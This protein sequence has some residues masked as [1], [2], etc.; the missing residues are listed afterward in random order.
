MTDPARAPA[1]PPTTTDE[2]AF[3]DV[4]GTLAKTTVVHYY[5]YFKRRRMPTFVGAIW[6]TCFL[7]KCLYFLLID[8]IDRGWF[9]TRFYKSYRG[10]PEAQIKALAEDCYREMLLPRRFAQA[11]EEIANHKQAGRRIVLVTGSIDFL[12]APLAAALGVDHVEAPRLATKQG[13]FTGHLEGPPLGAD[14]KK[15]RTQVYA[16]RQGI[17]LARSYAYGDSTADLAMLEA[18]GHPHVV[19]PGKSLRKIA[20]DR[21]WSIHDWTVKTQEGAAPK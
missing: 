7:F 16:Q 1:T 11:V 4:D 21:G 10:L 15:R 12:V 9:N 2:A 19:N 13:R 8:R 17:D 14:E 3:F 18:V 6:Q 5:A 20:T